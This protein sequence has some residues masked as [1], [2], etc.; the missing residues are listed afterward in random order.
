MPGQLVLARKPGQKILIGD[1][2]E[3]TL[4]EIRGNWARIAVSAPADVP[5]IRPD[6]KD[7]TP[8]RVVAAAAAEPVPASPPE[9][10]RHGTT[11]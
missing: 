1:N 6:A 9:E 11:V 7:K 2:I 8:R 10:L 3:I 5:I 4:F